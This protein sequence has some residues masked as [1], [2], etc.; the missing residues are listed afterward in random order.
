MHVQKEF[1]T[2]FRVIREATALIEAGFDVSIV[3]VETEQTLSTEEDIYGVHAKHIIR[4]S[5]FVPTRF[6]PWFLVKAVHM[7]L[8]GA[9]RLMQ[10]PSDIYH[11]HDE[12][13]LP[14]CYIAARLRR[15]PLI[16]DAHELPLEEPGITRWRR[17]SWLAAR[18]LAKMIPYCAGVIATSPP[19]AREIEKLYHA[20][21]VTLVRNTPVYREVSKG[22]RLRQHLGL[23]PQTRIAL[24]QGYIQDDRGLDKLVLAGKFLDP[25]T[26][27][28]MMG[29]AVPTTQARLEVLI[30]KEGVTDRV[31]IIPAVPYKELLDWTAS[32]NI[33][34]AILPLDYSLAVR[35][36]LP[37]K[38]FEYLMAGLPVLA[39][40]LYAISDIINTYDV[41]RVLPSLT[42][43]DIGAAISALLADGDACAR[44]HRNA[45]VAAQ[46]EFNWEKEKGQ[47]IGLYQKVLRRQEVSKS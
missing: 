25:N 20:P 13:A 47:L 5:W 22:D 43:E 36:M 42:P 12:K 28:V 3:D 29:K 45:L 34:L 15:K 14:A 39:S 8:T 6:K 23:G 38:F 2:D 32:A 27:I 26:V 1:R 16:F 19:T 44:M 40:P 17:L 33:G 24:Y 7:I 21:S 31:K 35:M 37:N 11:A 10:V 4:P 30:T 46:R 41:G 18:V 9:I